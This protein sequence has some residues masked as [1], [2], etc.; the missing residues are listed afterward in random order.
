MPKLEAIQIDNAKIKLESKYQPKLKRILD[1]MYGDIAILIK[2]DIR[3]NS[4]SVLDS[5]KPGIITVIREM[6]RETIKEFG[7]S[8]RSKSQDT[9]FDANN[10]KELIFYETKASDRIDGEVGEVNDKFSELA[11]LFLI[12]MSEKQADIIMDTTQREI[13]RAY[14]TAN[15]QYLQNLIE[16]DDKVNAIQGEVFTEDHLATNRAVD[17][18]IEGRDAFIAAAVIQAL[19]SNI[20]RRSSVI[21]EYNVGLA[22]SWARDTE[23]SLVKDSIRSGLITV[24]GKTPGVEERWVTMRDSRVRASHVLA[25]NQLKVDGFFT[26]MNEQLRYPRDNNGSPDNIFGCRCVVVRKFTK[27]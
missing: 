26:V 27:L 23:A 8:L 6:Y 19:R 3:F 14:I 25:D 4:D 5:Y 2:S 12:E 22:E 11:I 9:D 16:L 15:S 18:H 10:Q 13:A 21:T 20:T 17:E 1:Q 24:G 7:F